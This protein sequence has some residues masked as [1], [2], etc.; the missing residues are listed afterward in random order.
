[1]NN[2]NELIEKAGFSDL[3]RVNEPA[4][5]GILVVAKRKLERADKMQQKKLIQNYTNIGVRAFSNNL[6]C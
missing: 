2:G 3:K 4:L 1:M 6:S 5:L